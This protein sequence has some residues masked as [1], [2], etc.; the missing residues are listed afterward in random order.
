[1]FNILKDWHFRKLTEKTMEIA[2]GSQSFSS[3]YFEDMDRYNELT[4][5]CRDFFGRNIKVRIIGNSEVLPKTKSP[6][7]A[8]QRK[9]EAK[10]RSDLPPPVQDILHMFQG[11]IIGGAPAKR[12]GDDNPDA[13]HKKQEVTE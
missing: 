9:P 6:A 8:E 10:S 12:G 5:Y 11:E 1:M 2:K 4:H 13:L 7:D 3:N